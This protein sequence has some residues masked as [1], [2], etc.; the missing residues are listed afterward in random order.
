[1][2]ELLADRPKRITLGADKGYDTEDFVNEARSMN[3]TPHVTQ[4]LSRRRS[5]IDGRVTRHAGYVASPRIRKRIEE[6]FGWTRDRCDAP[7]KVPRAGTCRP[8]L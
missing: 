4:T 7:N 5:A 2:I 8:C 6:A 1:M 3:V